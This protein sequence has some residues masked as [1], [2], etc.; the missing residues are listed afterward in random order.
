MKTFKQF[1]EA[2]REGSLVTI[3]LKDLIIDKEELRLALDDFTKG[4]YAITFAHMDVA[5]YPDIKKFVLLDGHHRLIEN[6]FRE[7]TN[8][9]VNV[10]TVAKPETDKIWDRPKSW[11]SDKKKLFRWK[12]NK[13]HKGL[14]K[15]CKEEE[16]NV[17]KR[18]YMESGHDMTI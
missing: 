12:S 4:K 14:E 15:F 9:E 7:K 11:A 1:N 18:E 6:I 3:N 17:I 5:Y 2:V 10:H 13:K 16:L 8:V